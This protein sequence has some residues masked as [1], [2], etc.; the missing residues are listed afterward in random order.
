MAV[1]DIPKN[2]TY[3]KYEDYLEEYNEEK[4][5]KD[6]EKRLYRGIFR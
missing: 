1:Y 3:S 4:S 2:Y 6:K 5:K